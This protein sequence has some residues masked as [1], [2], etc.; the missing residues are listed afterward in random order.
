MKLQQLRYIVE[1]ARRKLN[2]SE[3]AEAL[4]TSQPGVSKQIKLL[5]DELGVVIFERSAKR[6]TGV[7]EP[8]AAVLESARRILKEAENLKRIGS[9][10]ADGEAG[11]FAIAATHTQARYALPTVVKKFTERFPRAKLSLHQGSPRQI[12]EWLIGGE[13]DVAVATES[14]DQFPEIL[15]L[16]C[17]QWS[18]VVVAPKGHAVLSAPLTLASLARWP[19]ITYDLAFAGR[20]KINHAFERAGLTPNV[21]LA[22]IDTDVIKTYVGLGM[23]LGIIADMAFDA[24]RDDGLVA[25]PAA[26]LFESNTTKLGLRRHAHLRKFEYSFAEAFAPQLT[27]RVIDAAMAAAAGEQPLDGI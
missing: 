17:R 10:Y 21:A 1:V 22:A 25:L 5:E 14:L 11:S 27:R 24:G 12:A 18:H 23:G 2:V 8:G 19:L 13:A 20:S 3:A 9:D 4:Y 16:P 26:H 6:F 7:T 15:A